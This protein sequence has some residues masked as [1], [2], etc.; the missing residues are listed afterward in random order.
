MACRCSKRFYYFCFFLSIFITS[1]KVH[2]ACSQS[3]HL[4]HFTEMKWHS[5]H[6]VLLLRVPIKIPPVDVALLYRPHWFQAINTVSPLSPPVS[7]LLHAT[8]ITSQ[9][10]DSQPF[11]GC[12]Y[13]R[14][15][16]PKPEFIRCVQAIIAH[17]QLVSASAASQMEVAHC[18]S[19]REFV[20]LWSITKRHKQFFCIQMDHLF[21]SFLC[22]PN[23]DTAEGLGHWLGHYCMLQTRDPTIPRCEASPA[24][25]GELN[26]SSQCRQ[27][28]SSYESD[29]GNKYLEHSV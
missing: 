3:N 26:K 11:K 1:Q 17:S 16:S 7:L 6:Q 2:Q 12:S 13:A 21:D 15:Q 9:A 18:N 5:R 20:T 27:I 29:Y 8:A 14:E 23:C 22:F 10:H 25:K 28:K 24:L 19:L 4:G